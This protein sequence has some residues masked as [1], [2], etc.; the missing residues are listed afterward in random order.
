MKHIKKITAVTLIA[1]M[2]FASQSLYSAEVLVEDIIVQDRTSLD[3]ILS[4]NPNMA[5]WVQED[6][7][8]V[9]LEDVPLM[10][11]MLKSW[12]TNEV[13]L[14]T[15]TPLQA[16]TQYS[17]LTLTGAEG[18]IDFKTPAWVEW[19]RVSNFMSMKSNDIESIEILDDRTILVTYRQALSELNYNFKLFAEVDIEQV[20]KND[21]Q[22]PV[23]SV[24][25]WSRLM[26][27][28]EYLLMFIDMRDVNGQVI[29]FDTGVF[30]FRT[31]EFDDDEYIIEENIDTTLYLDD[32]LSDED[33][34]EIEESMIDDMFPLEAAPEEEGNIEEMAGQISELDPETGAA[35]GILILLTLIMNVFFFKARL[36]KLIFA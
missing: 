32:E 6:T 23:I 31:P 10:W 16:N 18:S 11:G 13:E 8:L 5:Q 28:T 2:I 27:E 17:L 20:S 30:D 4:Q 12:S 29:Q 1:G 35:T 24:E 15:E 26:S 3:I 19:Y 25:M 36:K 33:V 34:R 7:E 22:L 14:I 21:F 9:I